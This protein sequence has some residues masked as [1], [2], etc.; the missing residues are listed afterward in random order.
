[1]LFNSEVNDASRN[2]ED[3]VLLLWGFSMTLVIFYPLSLGKYCFTS[4][5]SIS[6]SVT[7]AHP[8]SPTFL[9]GNS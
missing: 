2:E 6:L 1:M 8:T 5:P 4:C 7:R 9:N 3:L